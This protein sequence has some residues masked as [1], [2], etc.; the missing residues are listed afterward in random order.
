MLLCCRNS[1]G[2]IED[3]RE[4][5]NETNFEKNEENNASIEEKSNFSIHKSPFVILRFVAVD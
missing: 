3:I 1:L 2:I 4:S 5:I